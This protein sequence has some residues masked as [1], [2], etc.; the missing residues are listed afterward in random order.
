MLEFEGHIHS[1]LESHDLSLDMDVRISFSIGFDWLIYNSLD[2]IG[3]YSFSKCIGSYSLV[4]LSLRTRISRATQADAAPSGQS[5]IS[6]G[7]LFTLAD[8]GPDISMVSP[9]NL[10]PFLDNVPPGIHSCIIIIIYPF[11]AILN[12]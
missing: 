11:F 2:S 6:L 9:L 12:I 4:F 7:E 3:G 10:D 1:H 8:M 5:M